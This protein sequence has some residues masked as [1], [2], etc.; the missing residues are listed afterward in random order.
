M[1]KIKIIKDNISL[2]NILNM[3]NIKINSHG[4]CVCPIHGDKNPSLKVYHDGHFKCFGCGK[5]G[6]VIDLFRFIE[7]IDTETAIR[8]LCA[9]FN[10]NTIDTENKNYKPKVIMRPTPEIKQHFK[11]PKVIDYIKECEKFVSET[12]YFRKR[13]LLP[14]IVKRFRLGYDSNGSLFKKYF[15]KSKYISSP[16]VIPYNRGLTYFQSRSTIN[17]DFYKIP[18][19][20][21]GTEPI[22][23]VNAFSSSQ[24]IFIVE[25]PICAI[26]IA[27]CGGMA[28]PLCGVPNTTKLL[29]YLKDNYYNGTLI[30]CLDNDIAGENATKELINGIPE[31]KIKGLN[32]LKI[33]YLVENIADECKDPNELLMKKWY[34]LRVNI[35]RVLLKI[36]R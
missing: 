25:S 17:K 22:F 24:I 30:I 32:E 14:Y 5:R 9:K 6:D 7:N 10:L 13:G 33:N 8:I 3:Y 18:T 23:N 26:S 15:P 34:R 27:Q 28:V 19:Y 11:N 1:D 31:Q 35:K 4:M 2:Y 20:I 36:K 12:D 29:R 21:C 16:V